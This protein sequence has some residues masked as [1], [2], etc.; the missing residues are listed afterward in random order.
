MQSLLER[1]TTASALTAPVKVYE[2]SLRVARDV[3]IEEYRHLCMLPEYFQ[4][5]DLCSWSV[6]HFETDIPSVY[7]TCDT[8]T[9]IQR[10]MKRDRTSERA[11][12]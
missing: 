2:R 1:Y 10:V 11:M 5:R 7:L 12:R 3:F 9:M 4:L 6:K 8:G